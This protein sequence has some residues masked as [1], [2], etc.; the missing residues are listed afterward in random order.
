MQVAGKLNKWSEVTE[1]KRCLALLR[2]RM[3]EVIFN[4]GAVAVADKDF[5]TAVR[6]LEDVLQFGVE[7]V[8]A[9][10][11]SLS[12]GPWE[13]INLTESLSSDLRVLEADSRQ[14]AQAAC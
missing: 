3:G 8:K 1:E 2:L 10:L 7:E 6:L 12:W 4:Q 13:D 14:H 9:L 5:K 11:E